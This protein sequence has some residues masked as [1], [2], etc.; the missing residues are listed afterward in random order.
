MLRHYL[1]IIVVDV[2]ELITINYLFKYSIKQ[3]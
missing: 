1:N 2:Q 3:L